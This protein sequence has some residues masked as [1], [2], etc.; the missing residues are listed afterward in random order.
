MTLLMSLFLKF[1]VENHT[2]VDLHTNKDCNF[3]V[4]GKSCSTIS[5]E[6]FNKN[7]AGTSRNLRNTST[8]DRLPNK[9]TVREKQ[10]FFF[11]RYGIA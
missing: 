5:M 10:A 7:S 2:V 8:D 4:S 6:F 11:R 1:W 9:N 3:Q